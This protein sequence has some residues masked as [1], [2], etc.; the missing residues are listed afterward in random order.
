MCMSALPKV[1]TTSLR[2]TLPDWTHVLNND[3]EDIL[4][5]V[6]WLRHPIKRLQSWYSMYRHL[7]EPN[8]PTSPGPNG[9]GMENVRCWEAAVDYSFEYPDDPHYKPQLEQI[10]NWT[11]IH[12]FESIMIWFPQYFKGRYPHHRN[13]FEHFP[14]NNYRKADL[15]Q[16]YSEDLDTWLSL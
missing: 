1:G 3:I 15:E 4:L 5:R 13:G 7:Y 8:H 16:R 12:P 10:E 11:V 9:P 2:N 6:A 14:I